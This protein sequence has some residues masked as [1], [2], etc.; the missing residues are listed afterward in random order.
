MPGIHHINLRCSHLK[1]AK[2]FYRDTIGF[3]VVLAT[4]EL[5]E[6]Y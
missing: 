3:P 4:E 5:K 1:A 6:V 2:N